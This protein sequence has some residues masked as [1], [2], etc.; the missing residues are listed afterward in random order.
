[1]EGK[2]APFLESHALDHHNLNHHLSAFVKDGNATFVARINKFFAKDDLGIGL[3][4]QKTKAASWYP[5][6][7]KPIRICKFI[8]G[9]SPKMQYLTENV[10][11]G[12]LADI[13]TTD[14]EFTLHPRFLQD[15][16][17]LV[18]LI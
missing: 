18:N 7:E 5:R 8:V 15:L 4:F 6:Y 14:R 12:R 1:M 3:F 9:P 17:L 13:R 16:C 11:G 2:Q 10:C